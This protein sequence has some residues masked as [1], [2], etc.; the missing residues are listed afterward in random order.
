M[1]TD[2]Q[3]REYSL[4]LKLETDHKARIA[5]IETTNKHEMANHEDRFR[6]DIQLVEDEKHELVNELKKL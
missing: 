2:S 6:R 4:Q 1:A 3:Q 5:E